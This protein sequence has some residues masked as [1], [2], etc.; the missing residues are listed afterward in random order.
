MQQANTKT[1][2]PGA[3]A[4]MMSWIDARLPRH[5]NVRISHVA[6]LRAQEFQLLLLLR[7][8][9]D[10]RTDQPVGH[11]HLVDDELCTQ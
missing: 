9:V 11:R 8:L 1:N 10:V 5:R 4:G 3:L 7:L 6:V 2:K